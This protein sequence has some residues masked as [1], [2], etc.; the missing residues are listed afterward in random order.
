MNA[1]PV[2]AAPCEPE[3][4]RRNGAVALALV[5]LL[6]L[7]AYFN[8]FRG[9][10]MLDDLQF[11]QEPELR[12]PFTN[13]MA[14][15]RPVVSLS[16]SVNYWAD[17]M[18]PRGYHLFNLLVHVAAAL[19][20]FDL[21]RRTLLLPHFGGRY[22]DRAAVLAMAAALL[23]ELHPLQTQSVTYVVQRCE[24]MMGLFFLLTLY[25]FL[26]GAT[27]PRRPGWWY[28]GAVLSCA[29]GAGC[30]EVIAVAPAVV[31]LFDRTFLAGSWRGALRR[32][33]FYAALA[34]PAV[35]TVA[36]LVGRGLL[37]HEKGV[38]GF[39]TSLFTPKTYALTQPQVI[40]HYLR[41][42][43][44]PDALC[45]DYLDWPAVRTPADDPV[46]IGVVCSLVALTVVGVL[47][48]SGW[49]FLA[50]WFFLILAPTSSIVPVQDAVFE[51]R[52]YLPL[53]ALVVAAVLLADRGLE[54]VR[55]RVPGSGWYATRGALAA[56]V[57]LL[58]AY[59]IVTMR[60]N[61]AYA[62]RIALYTDNATKRPNNFRVRNNLAAELFSVRQEK[63]ALAHARRAAELS[64]R[65]ALYR[66]MVAQCLLELGEPEQALAELA[67][68]RELDPKA[69]NFRATLG[70]A[71]LILGRFGDAVPD[72]EAARDEAPWS[73]IVRFRLAVC[74]LELGRT[75]EA[76]DEIRT[77][78]E[79]N[80][81]YLPGLA[82]FIRLRAVE[83]DPNGTV[84]RHT[85]LCARALAFASGETPEALDTLAV[86]YATAAKF[87]EG[88]VAGGAVVGPAVAAGV[89]GRG[90]TGGSFELAAATAAKAAEK[91]AAAGNSYL[92]GRIAARAALFREHKRYLPT[93]RPA[94]AVV[95]G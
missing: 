12:H 47:L 44:W 77:I 83:A 71:E 57:V 65:M 24:S 22:T 94:G 58:V 34:V 46:S 55:V 79:A 62:S 54:L 27:A 40:L 21:V 10:F 93:E 19:T 42:A 63:A 28:A 72:F 43:A 78:R 87:D 70:Y 69:P 16:L 76:A 39:G 53:A 92:A 91:A 68:A 61:E 29:L 6:G 11:I 33:P 32:W 7:F 18:Q 74:L 88:L 13:A 37:S 20:L 9:A 89:A 35:A 30:K 48:R 81:E 4:G 86:A 38:V 5:S 67:V 75:T 15:G 25:C 23:W 80:P 85:V 45:L 73:E 50:A 56:A 36:V 90:A 26:R 82:E 1:P 51:H 49:G 41:L 3:S 84:V 59:G 95:K 17:K 2:P 52:M 60:R 14:A 8:A 31:F 64:P 66:V